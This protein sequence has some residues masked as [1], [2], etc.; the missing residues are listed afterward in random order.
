MLDFAGVEVLFL[1]AK[2]VLPRCAA[3]FHSCTFV[4][5]T[6]IL[7]GIDRL[8]LN[9]YCRYDFDYWY[10]LLIIGTY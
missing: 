2:G 9:Y 6:T 3:F 10:N 8:L 7:N 4:L 1:Q 5:K